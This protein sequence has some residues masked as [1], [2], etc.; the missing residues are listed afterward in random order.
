MTETIRSVITQADLDAGSGKMGYDYSNSLGDAESPC[1]SNPI[2]EGAIS[3]QALSIGAFVSVSDL[4]ALDSSEHVGVVPRSFN[5]I[6]MRDGP[7]Q[8]AIPSNGLSTPLG[9]RQAAIVSLGDEELL[10]TRMSKGLRTR[11]ITINVV[12]EQLLDEQLAERV[13]R[14]TNATKSQPLPMSMRLMEL[15]DEVFSTRYDGH[16]EKLLIESFALEFLARGLHA[17]LNSDM[18]RKRVLNARDRAKM[19]LVKDLLIAE[20]GN[21]HSLKSLAAEVGVSVTALKSKFSI[22]F[23]T[24]VFAYL[25]DVRLQQAY[26]K[27]EQE[28]WTVAEA[29]TFVGYAHPSNFS[30]AFKKRFGC[31]PSELRNCELRN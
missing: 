12:P 7:T 18:S 26:A 30:A 31:A 16:V 25:R 22:M 28:G 13:A 21:A 9:P 5:T 11:T 1:R 23:G 17:S 6:Y 24:S 27:I 3:I 15:A 29:A 20:P 10:S 8:A 4:I 14:A 2:F 19:L